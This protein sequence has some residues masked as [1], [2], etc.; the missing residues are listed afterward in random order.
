LSQPS[1]AVAYYN[2]GLILQQIVTNLGEFVIDGGVG[3]AAGMV[4]EDGEADR[5]H[6]LIRP[7]SGWI[8]LEI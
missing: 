2:R 5:D 3:E 6:L 1:L 7:G 8:I 4:E